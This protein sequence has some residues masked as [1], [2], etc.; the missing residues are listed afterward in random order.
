M[1]MIYFDSVSGRWFH[2]TD[3]ASFVWGKENKEISYSANNSSTCGFRV[4]N[5]AYNKIGPL[6]GVLTSPSVLNR[7]NDQP[8]QNILS[9]HQ[10][11]QKHGGLLVLFSLNNV[12]NSF[13]EGLIYNSGLSQWEPAILPF[14]D[15]IYNRYP[16]RK[17]EQ[18][19]LFQQRLTQLKKQQIPIINERF[20]SKWNVHQ[21]FSEHPFL[22]RHVPYTTLFQGFDDLK[23]ML[24]D[25]HYVYI[26]PIHSSKGRGIAS[27][28][29]TKD[30]AITYQNH[31]RTKSFPTLLELAKDTLTGY[32]GHL[33]LQ[34]G[35][36]SQ[37]YN[38]NRFDIRL[39][40]HKSHDQY[41]VSG[42]GIRQSLAQPLTTHV[43][44]GGQIL[45]IDQVQKHVDIPMLQQIAQ[46]S[47]EALSKGYN[48]IGEFSL[49]IVLSLHNHYYVLEANAKPMIF[50]EEAIQESGSQNLYNLFCEL[51]GFSP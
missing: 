19:L 35:I 50:D 39:L 2:Q 24:E 40:A 15:I 11:V 36:E 12:T 9:L 3:Q 28:T 14:P 33:I 13:I 1:T 16:N 8:H 45:S 26:K 42:I 17:K 46:A 44:N 23:S 41:I 7:M 29:R 22:R 34:E 49:D 25:Y 6:I 48:L 4:K 51:T 32:E 21:L 37:T 38:G 43:I 20:F 10:I 47:G 18:T 5:T 30:G 31:Y 27:L